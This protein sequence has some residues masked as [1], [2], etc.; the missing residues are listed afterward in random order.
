MGKKCPVKQNKCD[1][2]YDMGKRGKI[3]FRQPDLCAG[4]WKRKVCGT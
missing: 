2:V 3:R 4:C 1:P